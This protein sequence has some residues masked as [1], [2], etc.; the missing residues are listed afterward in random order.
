MLRNACFLFLLSTGI[1]L[2]GNSYFNGSL[3]NRFNLSGELKSPPDALYEWNI[4]TQAP[5]KYRLLHRT[6]ILGTYHLVAEEDNNHLFFRL[7]QVYSLI[8]QAGA[9]IVFYLLLRLLRFQKLALWGAALFAVMPPM[10]MAYSVP[11]HTRE[12]MLA[13]ALLCAGLIF[14]IRNNLPGMVIIFLLGV[15]CRETLLLLPLVNLLF[16]RRQAMPVRI[17]IFAASMAVFV[18]IRFL[19]GAEDYD[20]WEGLKWNLA[21]LPQ[22]AGFTF[23]SFGFLWLPFFFWIFTPRDPNNDTA[24]I[25]Q[26]SVM[27]LMVILGTTFLGGIFNEIRL[28]YLMAPWVIAGALAF[29]RSK[30]PV[31]MR[32]LTRSY[33][34]FSLLLLLVFAAGT[35]LLLQQLDKIIPPSEHNISYGSWAVI[36][37]VQ[38]YLTGVT[39]PVFFKTSA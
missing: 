36:T 7:Y 27:V 8:F 9:V 13:Y 12:D 15:F 24:V 5:F 34:L 17:L 22:V 28:L 2:L 23:I 38:L 35:A 33:L 19:L 37:A 29:Y 18:A 3:H 25:H 4:G 20:V 6:L 21:H 30:E 10:L 26:S 39:L 31:V 32:L 1:F 14:M 11:V 16:N